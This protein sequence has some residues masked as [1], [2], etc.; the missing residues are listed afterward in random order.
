MLKEGL[1]QNG[2]IANSEI[3]SDLKD[4]ITPN[5]QLDLTSHEEEIRKALG[6]ELIF[7]L[8]NTSGVFK[9]GLPKDQVA[10]T[11]VSILESGDYQEVLSGNMND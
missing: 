7:H 9:F 1:I 11:A 5:L 6:K 2:E 8:E 4:L 10:L 3:L